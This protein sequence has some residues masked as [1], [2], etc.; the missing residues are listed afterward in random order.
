MR[1]SRRAALSD[2]ERDAVLVDGER[3]R[4]GRAQVRE[5]DAEGDGN[6]PGVV[7]PPD[8]CQPGTA[9]APPPTTRSPTSASLRPMRVVMVRASSFSFRSSTA[10]SASQHRLEVAGRARPDGRA[11][12]PMPSAVAAWRVAVS[13]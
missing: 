13:T 4:L 8:G 11:A 1:I 9:R 12:G 3:V 7:P 6:V 2:H 5:Q 10:R